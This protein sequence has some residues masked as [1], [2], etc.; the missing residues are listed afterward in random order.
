MT[1]TVEDDVPIPPPRRRG[2]PRSE[3]SRR[4]ADLRVGQRA[5]C[6]TEGEFHVVRETIKKLGGRY[7]SRKIGEKWYVWR[8]G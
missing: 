3:A 2:R 7:T 8:I 5:V 4:A 6:E 1:V